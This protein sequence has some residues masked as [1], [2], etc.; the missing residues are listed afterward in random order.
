M[1]SVRGAVITMS[2][3]GLKV[4]AESFELSDAGCCRWLKDASGS[5]AL[6]DESFCP[7]S[8]F[9]RGPSIVCARTSGIRTRPG[10]VRRRWVRRNTC[11]LWGVVVGWVNKA[12]SYRLSGAMARKAGSDRVGEWAGSPLK[13]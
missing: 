11:I 13:H 3:P 1:V 10:L 4:L 2:L 6:C 8:M 9:I 7:L 12:G 5:A